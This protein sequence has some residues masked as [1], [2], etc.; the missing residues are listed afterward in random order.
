M[1]I[2]GQAFFL[3]TVRILKYMFIAAFTRAVYGCVLCNAVRFL[4]VT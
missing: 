4:D 1:L 3:I 2:Y